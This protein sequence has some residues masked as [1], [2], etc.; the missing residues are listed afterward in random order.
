MLNAFA[1]S[2]VGSDMLIADDPQIEGLRLLMP[3]RSGLLRDRGGD[4]RRERHGAR[5][6]QLRAYIDI[7]VAADR[8]IA[9]G[10]FQKID[11]AES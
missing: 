10:Q 2:L 3:R 7:A 11:G 6:E 5:L 1:R 4:R 9:C 8:R